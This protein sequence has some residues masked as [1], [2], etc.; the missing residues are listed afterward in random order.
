MTQQLFLVSIDTEAPAGNDAVN[1]MIYC[2]TDAGEYGINHI[3]DMLDCYDIKGLFFVDIAEAWH[4]GEEKIKK[5][6]LDINNRKHDIGVHIH[7]DHM[8]DP[9]RMFLWQYSF[10]EQYEIIKKCTEFYERVL[11]RKPLSFRAGRYGADNNTIR[12]L[13]KLGYKY[14]MSMYYGMKKRCKMDGKYETINKVKLL[15]GGVY[16][17]PVTVFKSFDFLGYKRFDKL[18]ESMPYGEFV[19]VVNEMLTTKSVSI[20]SFFMHSFSFVNWRKNPDDP[21][22]NSRN[23]NRID[24]M[25]RYILE[26]NLGCFISEGELEKIKTENIQEKHDVMQLFSPKYALLRAYKIMREKLIRNI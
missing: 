14:D 20:A 22:F 8:A 4:Y 3:M 19:G 23:H 12:I 25:F 10:D 9:D 7:P 16:E 1:N 24:S 13:S 11:G 15:P 2:K 6:L 5:V 17:I 21:D 18:D 26:C